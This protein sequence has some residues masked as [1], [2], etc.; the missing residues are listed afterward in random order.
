MILSLQSVH[1]CD[2]YKESV[3]SGEPPI[4]L[5]L[6]RV[7]GIFDEGLPEIQEF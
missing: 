3:L 2:S 1:S 6:M 4:S 5:I 7:V